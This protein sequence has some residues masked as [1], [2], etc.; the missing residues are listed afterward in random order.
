M[1]V[2][3]KCDYKFLLCGFEFVMSTVYFY[4]KR[5]DKVYGEMINDKLRYVDSQKSS[6]YELLIIDKR[7]G[8]HI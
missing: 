2:Q 6:R 8:S 5:Y 7:I 3:L 1:N 4:S